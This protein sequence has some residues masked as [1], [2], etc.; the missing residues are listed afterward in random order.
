MLRFIFLS[1]GTRYIRI[2]MGRCNG[3]I[4]R[5][6]TV[7]NH[8]L[9]WFVVYCTFFNASGQKESGSFSKETKNIKQ[10]EETHESCLDDVQ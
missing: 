3:I 7:Y 8:I 9:S 2:C 1:E 4:P 10:D 5:A 6:M